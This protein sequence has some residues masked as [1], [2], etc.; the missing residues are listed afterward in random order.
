MRIAACPLTVLAESSSLLL[1]QVTIEIPDKLAQQLGPGRERLAEI[2]ARGLR[3]SWAGTSGLR[4]EVIAFSARRPTAE[5]ILEF[6]PSSTV[7]ER[8]RELLDR[9]H[10]D[11]LTPEEEAELEDLAEVDR[12]VSLIKTEVV[13]QTSART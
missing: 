8:S 12:F 13:R 7:A 5:E 1:V 3:R 11:V 6:R 10:E 4:R 9:K 2:I